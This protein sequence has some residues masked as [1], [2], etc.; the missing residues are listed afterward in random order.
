MVLMSVMH[1]PCCGDFGDLF[2]ASSS[3]TILLGE[4]DAD[5]RRGYRVS[6]ISPTGMGECGRM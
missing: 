3:A 6:L 4:L 2:P 1:G 5:D